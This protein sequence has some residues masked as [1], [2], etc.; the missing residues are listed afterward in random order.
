MENV[1]GVKR[2][3][4]RKESRY[5]RRYQLEFKL[6][7][8]KLRLEEGLPVSLLSKEVGCS[9]DVG[10]RRGIRKYHYSFSK[11]IFTLS[12]ISC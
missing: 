4:K 3:S 5:G 8:V 6:R 2:R 10:I 12:G 9:Q 11:E 7:C 1:A